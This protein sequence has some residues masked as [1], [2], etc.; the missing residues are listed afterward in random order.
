M[1]TGREFTPIRLEIFFDDL[2]SEEKA[3][4]CTLQAAS[5]CVHRVGGG[6]HK[7]RVQKDP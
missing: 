5:L 6:R 2:S 3:A 4:S 7:K 1:T